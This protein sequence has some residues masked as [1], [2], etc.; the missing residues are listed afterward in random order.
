MASCEPDYALVIARF[1]RIVRITGS[2]LDGSH[3]VPLESRYS[4][5]DVMGHLSRVAN[6]DI[7]RGMEDRRPRVIVSDS[8]VEIIRVGDQAHFSLCILSTRFKYN[9]SLH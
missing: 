4:Y 5:S 8:K 7:E 3:S 2:L 1:L 6:F 9:S